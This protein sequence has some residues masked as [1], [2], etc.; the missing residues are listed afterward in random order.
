[1]TDDTVTER[2]A[3]ERRLIDAIKS[4]PEAVATFVHQHGHTEKLLDR[5]TTSSD[6][7]A[8][9]D[10]TGEKDRLNQVVEDNTGE[11]A[12]GLE[13]VVQ[14]ERDGDL[15][16]LVGLANTVSLLAA[17]VDDDIIMSVSELG[18]SLGEIAD[19]TANPDT[20]VGIQA[21][22]NGI[23]EGANGSTGRMGII[24]LVRALRDPNVQRGL[25][26]LIAVTRSTGEDLQQQYE[27]IE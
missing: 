12:N 27:G 20:V 19:T 4:D 23:G 2:E 6:T 25:G 1:M 11:L 3:T 9:K 16:T 8:A 21:L 15:E 24:G 26:F 10:I 14:L 13:R 22:M 5:T 17:A 18:S 7:T